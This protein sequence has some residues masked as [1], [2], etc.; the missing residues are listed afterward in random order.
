MR[1]GTCQRCARRNQWINLLDGAGKF[2][3][4]DAEVR[5][6]RQDD[7]ARLRSLR[8]AEVCADCFERITHERLARRAANGDREA[9]QTCLGV[10]TNQSMQREYQ[11]RK[12]QV[13]AAL[14]SEL[15]RYEKRSLI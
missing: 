3:A 4:A 12:V 13:C 11:Q 9:L 6:T 7:E 5:L 14:A 2:F 1:K 15:E 10:Q 8:A